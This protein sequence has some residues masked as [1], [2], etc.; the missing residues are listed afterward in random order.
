MSDSEH[1]TTDF[2][3]HP[4]AAI[5]GTN[6]ILMVYSIGL[7]ILVAISAVTFLF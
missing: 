7:G 1:E 2:E 4:L 3:P 6:H 5:W